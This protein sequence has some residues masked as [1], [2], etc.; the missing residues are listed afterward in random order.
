MLVDQGYLS[1][2][3]SYNML[4]EQGY[5]IRLSLVQHVS[6]SRLFIRL[7][8]VQHVSGAKSFYPAISRT[9]CLSGYL[10]YNMLVEQGHLP[11]YLS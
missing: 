7:S 4:V 11:G 10:S 2:Y 6:G 1:G 8:L 3:L 9:L 5:F